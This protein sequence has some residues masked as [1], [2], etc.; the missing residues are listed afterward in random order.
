MSPS[1][2]RIFSKDEAAEIRNVKESAEFQEAIVSQATADRDQNDVR[3][4]VI[5]NVDSGKSTMVGVM[6]KSIMETQWDEW[7]TNDY[8]E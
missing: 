5:G 2:I 6:T 8:S 7:W 1:D 4:A 3:I